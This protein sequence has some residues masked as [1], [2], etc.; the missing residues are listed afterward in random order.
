MDK[1]K[2][3]ADTAKVTEE[4]K[5]I[6]RDTGEGVRKIAAKV[7]NGLSSKQK[8]SLLADKKLIELEPGASATVKITRSGSALDAMQL[9]L[10]PSSTS[11][12]IVSGGEFKAG[13]SDSAIVIEAAAGARNGSV[14]V[15]GNGDSQS[16]DVVV[17][18]KI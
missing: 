11:N 14:S 18:G 16:V 6:A 13:E 7:E 10:T 2:M 3:R 4:V 1:A 5:D 17:K 9:T 8:P 15:E 12:L